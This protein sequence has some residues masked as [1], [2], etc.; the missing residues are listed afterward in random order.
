MKAFRRIL[1][2]VD[3]SEATRAA[4]PPA[5]AIAKAYEAELFFVHVLDFPYETVALERYYLE[6][7]DEANRR[8]TEL[9]HGLDSDGLSVHAAVL[10]G[11][12]YD[13]VVEFAGQQSVDLIVAATHG[14]GGIDRL[15][16]GSV[17]E[18]IVRLAPC[19]VLTVPPGY[20]EAAGYRPSRIV[21]AT[22]FS[23]IADEALPVAV[24][25]AQRFGADLTLVHVV[26]IAERGEYGESWQ[27]PVLPA[28]VAGEQIEQ[29]NQGLN[30][31]GRD[32]G[33]EAMHVETHLIRG[34]YPAIEIAEFSESVQAGMVVV[35]SHGRSGIGRV[36]LGSTTEKLIRYSKVPVLAVRPG[37]D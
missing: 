5:V 27:F 3:L 18:R 34:T 22:D 6:I 21:M 26:T 13:K 35:A 37:R 9:I 19:P 31:R 28:E 14:R 29:A 24:S 11:T 36:L 23:E 8:L 32:A 16:V 17:A 25:M 10:R 1:C 33:G 12:P 2:P 4:L 30:R 15:V 20:S 7:E